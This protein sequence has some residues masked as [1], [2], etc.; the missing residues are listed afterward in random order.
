MSHKRSTSRSECSPPERT[1]EPQGV[2]QEEGKDC[3]VLDKEH[4]AAGL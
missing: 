2:C 4:E 1:V 3:V